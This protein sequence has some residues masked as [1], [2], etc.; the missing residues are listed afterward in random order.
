MPIPLCTSI[1][2]LKSKGG[3][4]GTRHP[5]AECRWASVT[6]VVWNEKILTF[7]GFHIG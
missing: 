4:E 6:R 1:A 7:A 2:C 5:L 3:R